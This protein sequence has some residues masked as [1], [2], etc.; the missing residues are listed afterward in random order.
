MDAGHIYAILLAG[1]FA[2][3]AGVV[4]SAALMKRKVLASDV[5]SH[6]ALPGLG[7]AFA[8][9][10]STLDIPLVQGIT[11]VITVMVLVANLVTDLAYAVLDPRVRIS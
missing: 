7:L 4:G 10:A 8:R 3:A 9:A 1:F 5:I 11:I 6:L 2:I